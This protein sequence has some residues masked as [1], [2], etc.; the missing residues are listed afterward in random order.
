MKRRYA[1]LVI[2]VA[3]AVG[4]GAARAADREV[5]LHAVNGSFDSVKDKVVFAIENHGLVLNYTAHVGDML[6]RTGKDI[7]SGKKLFAQAEVLE[8]CSA[9]L[10]RQ[11]MEADPHN[12]AFCPYAIAVYALPG[13]TGKAYI[14]YRRPPG[15]K[16]MQPVARLLAEIVR[17]AL[18]GP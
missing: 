8:F 17:D 3:F 16:A 14:S 6:E 7:G 15:S 10:S 2:G 1:G 12:V 5:V 13:N 11:A 18:A 4:I 9:Q